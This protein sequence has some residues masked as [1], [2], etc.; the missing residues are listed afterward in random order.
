MYACMY[1][2][3]CMY[4]CMYVRVRVRVYVCMYVCMCACV[5]VFARVCMYVCM[6]ACVYVCVYV[7][8]CVCVYVMDRPRLIRLLHCDFQDTYIVLPPSVSSLYQSHTSDEAQDFTYGDITV[9]TWFH[10][11]MVHVTES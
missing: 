10:K 9:V 1:I 8:A 2:R 3:I 6:C 4:V 5:Y 7:R 11:I